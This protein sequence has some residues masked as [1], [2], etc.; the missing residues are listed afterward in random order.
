MSRN[1]LPSPTRVDQ[2]LDE[3]LNT[4]RSSGRQPS[5]L[6]LAR[7]F[8]LSNTT[9]RRNFPEVVSKIA[10]ARRPQEAPVAPEGPSPNDRLIARN[11]KLR[12]A[13][14]ELTATVN[15]AVAQIHRLSVE[16]RQMRAEL[17]AATGVTH[18]SDHIP[19]RRTPQ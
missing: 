6:D 11:A 9:F 7:R 8:G 16:N 1:D 17:E 19:S 15:L 12:R 14:R 2:A 18:L 4:C 3:L 5:V 13:N 10:A